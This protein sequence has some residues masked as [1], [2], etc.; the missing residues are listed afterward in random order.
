MLCLTAETGH[1]RRACVIVQSW[2]AA[3]R[4][5]IW[6]SDHSNAMIGNSFVGW[7]RGNE[8]FILAK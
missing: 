2:E 8:T 5:K 4:L 6:K 1:S 3:L 7:A